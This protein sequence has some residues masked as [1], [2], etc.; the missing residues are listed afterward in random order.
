MR[1][2]SLLLVLSVLLGGCGTAIE[3]SKV[4]RRF[5]TT[6]S[7]RD[8]KVYGTSGGYRVEGCGV[9]AHYACFR[10]ARSHHHHHDG[11]DSL[12]GAVA[13]ALVDSAFAVDQCVME[14]ADRTSEATAGSEL[15]APVFAMRPATGPVV[16]T[17][18]LLTG[19]RLVWLGKPAQHPDHVLVHVYTHRRL[20]PSCTAEIYSD[21]EPVPIERTERAGDFEARVLLRADSLRGVD[22]ALRYAGDL[23][24]LAFELRDADRK[25]VAKFAAR[26]AEERAHHAAKSSAASAP[27]SQDGACATP[28]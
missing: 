18:L 23:C 5:E 20:P 2:P 13:E 26:F 8:S 24:G 6:F 25:T 9:T 21:G 19:G 28:P 3:Q 11:S 22:R 14:H 15:A 7:C 16:K 10:S 4:L 27:P 12:G 1:V 17:R